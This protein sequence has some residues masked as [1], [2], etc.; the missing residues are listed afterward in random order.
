MDR[1]EKAEQ[2]VKVLFSDKVDKAGCAYYGHCEFVASYS[3]N[4]ALA[5]GLGEEKASLLYLV[6]LC[7][8]VLEDTDTTEEE[9]SS[10][11]GE[12][13]LALVKILT[14]RGDDYDAY[15]SSVKKN[16]LASIVKLA[17]AT[18]N[19]DITRFPALMRDE[20]RWKKSLKYAN[21]VRILSDLVKDAY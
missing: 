21:N 3:Y 5:L 17:D 6:G 11:I 8:D 14:N 16:R 2:F 4:Y 1:R 19:A 13:A 10:Y 9:L 12:E 20:K 7:H 15:F 18:H